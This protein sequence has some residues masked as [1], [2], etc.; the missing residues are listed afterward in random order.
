MKE[1]TQQIQHV[2]CKLKPVTYIYFSLYSTHAS[3]NNSS[4]QLSFALCATDEDHAVVEMSETVVEYEV[5]PAT[6]A[7]T[8]GIV[9]LGLLPG[10]G[11]WPVHQILFGVS[12]HGK[13][14]HSQCKHP[15][16]K[17]R[18]GS[19][20]ILVQFTIMENRASGPRNN[21]PCSA[22][23]SWIKNSRYQQFCTQLH[24]FMHKVIKLIRVL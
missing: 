20:G 19:K 1:M 24:L 2:H 8:E 7:L 13:E 11:T 17:H 18:N 23:F 16:I 4:A 10:F 6:I 22:R 21:L 3:R 5:S 15:V 12:W 9:K 14:H